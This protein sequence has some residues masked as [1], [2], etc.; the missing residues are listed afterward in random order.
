MPHCASPSWLL[1]GSFKSVSMHLTL[2]GSKYPGGC[3]GRGSERLPVDNNRKDTPLPPVINILEGQ[4][5]EG[6]AL[7][8]KVGKKKV[9]LA[10][11]V[12]LSASLNGFML[13]L[14]S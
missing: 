4:G 9:T 6:G 3:G 12:L 7:K 14:G 1:Q 8:K 10:D 13:F 5:A 11:P 2:S